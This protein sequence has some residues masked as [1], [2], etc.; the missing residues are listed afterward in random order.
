MGLLKLGTRARRWLKGSTYSSAFCLSLFAFSIQL[1][2]GQSVADTLK[3]Q[4]GIAGLMAVCNGDMSGWEKIE[5]FLAKAN[6]SVFRSYLQESFTKAQLENVVAVNG[7]EQKLP[8]DG[9][10]STGMLAKMKQV[11]ITNMNDLINAP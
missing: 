7:I 9:L 4:G 3:M 11:L 10:K 6:S 8:C 1:A 2:H 5:Q